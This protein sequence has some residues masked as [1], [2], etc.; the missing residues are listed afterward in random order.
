[1]ARIRTIKPEIWMSPQVMNLSHGARLLFVGLITQADDAGRGSADPRKLKAAIFGGDDITSTDV[2][3]WLDECSSQGLAV[4]YMSEKH[5]V[6]YQLPS[7]K[8]HQ[9]IDRP[10]QSAYPTLDESQCIRRMLDEPHTK[11]REGSDRTGPD[12][13]GPDLTVPRARET[14]GIGGEVVAGNAR[15]TSARA[16]VAGSDDGVLMDAFAAVRSAYPIKAGRLDWLTAEHNWRLRLDEGHTPDVLLLAVERY[17]AFVAA[18]GVSG[19]LFVLG[20]EKFFGAADKPWL[21]PWDPPKG[22]AAQTIDDNIAA[23]QAW[24]EG[25]GT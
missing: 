17:A 18:G 9:S 11:P 21:Q 16:P 2:R 5:G 3:R 22:K 14:D 15:E 10:R 23:G 13:T 4:F 19:P 7:W 6:L 1:M 12:T 8:S 25:S 24:L 20:P